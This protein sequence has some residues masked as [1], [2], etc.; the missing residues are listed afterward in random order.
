M[1]KSAVKSKPL[2]IFISNFKIPFR[3]L[4]N[5]KKIMLISHLSFLEGKYQNNEEEKNPYFNR[6][7]LE[8]HFSKIYKNTSVHHYRCQTGPLENLNTKRKTIKDVEK[9]FGNLDLIRKVSTK[10]MIYQEQ[11]LDEQK[12]LGM[13]YVYLEYEEEEENKIKKTNEFEMYK[14]RKKNHI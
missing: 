2:K 7:S 10:K 3:I 6:E 9:M 4:L 11:S 8:I 1:K 14:K 13:G 12:E 5:K